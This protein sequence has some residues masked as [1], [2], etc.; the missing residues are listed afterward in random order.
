VKECTSSGGGIA[1]WRGFVIPAGFRELGEAKSATASGA[2]ISDG[3][4]LS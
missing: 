3:C 4:F 2:G 1:G